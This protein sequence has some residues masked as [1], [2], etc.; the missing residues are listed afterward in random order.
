MSL[1]DPPTG[2][3][4]GGGS[5]LREF[6]PPPP[7]PEPPKPPALPQNTAP[8]ATVVGT[9][10]SEAVNLDVPEP[11]QPQ[12][13]IVRGGVDSIAS[14]TAGESNGTSAIRTLGDALVA[15]PKLCDASSGWQIGVIRT[16]PKMYGG[17][18]I[19]GDQGLFPAMT[20]ADFE[21]TFGGGTFHIRIVTASPSRTDPNGA[22][23]QLPKFEFK[24]QTPGVPKMANVPS[25]VPVNVGFGDGAFRVIGD[26]AKTVME[27]GHRNGDNGGSGALGA[28]TDLSSQTM[29]AQSEMAKL[30]A[31]G[32]QEQLRA[33]RAK[34]ERLEQRILDAQ[35]QNP[36]NRYFEQ[37]MGVGNLQDQ[38]SRT[39]QDYDA[40]IE[41]MNLD[42]NEQRRVLQ[43]AFDR[44]LEMEKA[45][46]QRQYDSA[47]SEHAQERSRLTDLYESKLK[48]AQDDR[49]R[50]MEMVRRDHDRQLESMRNDHSR[51]LEML[52][53]DMTRMEASLRS[54]HA[55]D[56][57]Q[58]EA[59]A[60]IL[61]DQRDAELGRCRAELHEKKVELERYQ[62]EAHKP[63]HQQ[64]IENAQRAKALGYVKPEDA[65]EA[66]PSTTDKLLDFAKAMAPGL[67][68]AM[69]PVIAQMMS[70]AMGG[71][72]APQAALPNGA[73]APQQLP[74]PQQQQQPRQQ[75]QPQQQRGQVKPRPARMPDTNVVQAAQEGSIPVR[76]HG[77]PISKT[78][79]A[80]PP[81]VPLHQDNGTP[82]E[83]PPDAPSVEEAPA[84]AQVIQQA[85][86]QR[87][88]SD[89]RIA[90]LQAGLKFGPPPPGFNQQQLT[91]FVGQF[92]EHAA[93]SYAADKSPPVFAAEAKVQLG[94]LTPVVLAWMSADTAA[95]LLELMTDG[96]AGWALPGQR[97]W[98]RDVW[99]ELAKP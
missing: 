90:E 10:L 96:R 81:G 99:T 34:A 27:S 58:Q 42:F 61:I 46:A 39:R 87:N 5:R 6:I 85:P 16:Q 91:G 63:F 94:T 56:Q 25:S 80:E 35:A 48:A 33:E 53:Q 7:P 50:E 68:P 66:P 41:R 70:R 82:V 8:L 60:K 54:D 79:P 83:M 72:Q 20:D 52:R 28:F 69:G 76:P 95:N 32:L 13:E 36:Q 62:A 57:K 86:P 14:G 22:P 24:Y 38:L 30:S 43:A 9:S 74:G 18:I 4:A 51:A 37:A 59:M 15:Y 3:P 12:R 89:A 1:L 21:Q 93:S 55:R 97:E 31:E 73:P 49:I 64:L 44:Q 40:R 17:A 84:Q 29:R 98:L 45:N 65:G 19:A 71:G 77:P 88:L 47:R 75:Q 67:A 11:P 2:L 78:G 26:L 23:L 92:G